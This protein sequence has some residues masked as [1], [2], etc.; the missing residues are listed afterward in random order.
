MLDGISWRIPHKVVY[1]QFSGTMCMQDVREMMQQGYE[2]IEAEG[3]DTGVH[4]VV[5]VSRCERYARD[6]MNLQEMRSII[7][8]H[9]R[10]GWVVIVDA[11]P[12]PVMRF[13]S[14]SVIKL[15]K[16]NYAVVNT[17]AEAITTLQ[18]IDKELTQV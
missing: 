1:S 2:M 11:T 15:L 4:G 3:S 17:E 18:R 13:I 16:V 5:D 7:R 9:P 14:M 8:L 10:A 6:L 12:H